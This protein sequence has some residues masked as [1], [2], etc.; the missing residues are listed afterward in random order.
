VLVQL[1]RLE[2]GGEFQ[3]YLKSSQILHPESLLVCIDEDQNTINDGFFANVAVASLAS[4]VQLNDTPA[5]YHGGSS[6]MSFA[7]GHAE[8]HKWLGFTSA[9]AIKAASLEGSGGL[10][11]TDLSS[12]NDLHYLL[13]V[14][15]TPTS[16]SWQ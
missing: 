7:D 6:G 9:E 12:L 11:L 4:A 16:G 3:T 10:T 2:G 14:C 1:A 15:T 13:Q 5:T 8:L